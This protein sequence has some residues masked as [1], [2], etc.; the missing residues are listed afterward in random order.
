MVENAELSV[1]KPLLRSFLWIILTTVSMFAI[2][3]FIYL[4]I[5]SNHDF[6][7]RVVEIRDDAY[8]IQ[9]LEYQFH[10]L[11]WKE[12][13]F[14]T[15]GTSANINNL[16]TKTH[17]ALLQ[18]EALIEEKGKSDTL[19][20]NN[21]KR[22][23]TSLSALEKSLPELIDNYRKR[24]FKDFGLEGEL[25]KAVHALEKAELN[26]E[27]VLMLRRH[28][29]DFFLRKDMKY[30]EK[31]DGDLEKLNSEIQAVADPVQKQAFSAM[32]TQYQEGFKQIINIEKEIGLG[33]FDGIRG[34][35]LKANNAI[36]VDAEA[37][38]AY[39]IQK[40]K[41]SEKEA[42]VILLFFVVILGFVFTWQI[43]NLVLRIE[44]PFLYFQNSLE[45]M[46]RG[47]RPEG[48]DEAKA[49]KLMQAAYKPVQAIVTRL[50]KL[51]EF[52]AAIGKKE[53]E[54]SLELNLQEDELAR[55]LSDM[56]NELRSS[57]EQGRQRQWV[58]ESLSQ[59]SEVVRKVQD[60][61]EA[62][63]NDALIY[64]CRRTNLNQGFIFTYDLDKKELLLQAA[65]AYNRKKFAEKTLIPGEG[66]VGQCFLEKEPIF[67]TEVPQNYY[68]ITSGLGEALPENIIIY[69]L[70][71]DGE[72]VGVLELASFYKLQPF[73]ME[74]L[75]KATEH[76]AAMLHR[77]RS[78]QRLR[79]LYETATEMQEKQRQ[80]EEEL[81]Q[82]LE[83][84]M[85]QQEEM[86]RR[87]KD[88][89]ERIHELEDQP[90]AS[91]MN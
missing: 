69:P 77:S 9:V 30:S 59:F 60:S 34:E 74:G 14:I 87:E 79:E 5:D 72:V 58:A 17:H 10:Q 64:L 88:F 26:K 23:H 4:R 12:E 24:G 83:E 15:Q 38:N 73:E 29:K 54:T 67:L 85:A 68:A 31:F 21:L 90:K 35:R 6:K 40:I 25:R 33:D 3:L 65:Y 62:L 47:L 70:M 42:L 52:A 81:R 84:L 51:Q 91:R 41:A 50:S 89:V 27:L 76:L 71:H 56:R 82:N 44:R 43:R 11:G 46:A 20:Y 7:Q 13:E 16:T 86:Q 66:L 37:L 28:E 45:K 32:L 19:L 61:T 36:Q 55:G 22:L 48:I 1:K 57:D 49:D 2:T 80:T 39:V 18:I 63:L 75:Q 78:Q 53:Y 8:Q